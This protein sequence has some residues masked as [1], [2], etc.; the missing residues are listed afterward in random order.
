MATL[1]AAGQF[2][3]CRPDGS[4]YATTERDGQ[5]S[6]SDHYILN[7][8]PQWVAQWKS[9]EQAAQVMAPILAHVSELRTQEGAG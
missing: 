4:L 6:E 5:E 3:W 8:Y 2:W 9:W 7:A 1:A